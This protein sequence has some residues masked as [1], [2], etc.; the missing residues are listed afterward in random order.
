MASKLGLRR[1]LLCNPPCEAMQVAFDS[2]RALRCRC[3]RRRRRR[4]LLFLK[5]YAPSACVRRRELHTEHG[6]RERGSKQNLRPGFHCASH[7]AFIIINTAIHE[8]TAPPFH[9]SLCVG[10]RVVCFLPNVLSPGARRGRRHENYAA[11]DALRRTFIFKQHHHSI[12]QIESWRLNRLVLHSQKDP[13]S[14]LK[15][16]LQ[17]DG[18]HPEYRIGYWKK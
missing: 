13:F 8:S 14:N 12:D 2:A 10:R 7:A 17:M 3:R 16:A 15:Q 4:L 11:A 9:S 18:I 1:S 5:A 6:E